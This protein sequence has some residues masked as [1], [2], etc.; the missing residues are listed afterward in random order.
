[1]PSW[2]SYTLSK[3]EKSLVHKTKQEGKEQE[4][5]AAAALAM[6]MRPQKP[7]AT[8]WQPLKLFAYSQ[9]SSLVRRATL[10][11][12]DRVPKYEKVHNFK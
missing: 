11:D 5:L 4:L 8:L 12:N 6:R 7:P 3:A 10:K 9:L 2:E 1:M